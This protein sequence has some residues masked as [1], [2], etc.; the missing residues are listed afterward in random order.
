M[1]DT[2]ISVSDSTHTCIIYVRRFLHLDANI[3]NYHEW[4]EN[5]GYIFCGT[6]VGLAG[7]SPM[8]LCTIEM[9]FLVHYVSVV[10][11]FTMCLL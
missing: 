10:C 7:V 11:P 8:L 2:D 4:I 1:I 9:V 5:Q 6:V 3:N